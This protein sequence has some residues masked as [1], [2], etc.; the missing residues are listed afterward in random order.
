MKV[1]IKKIRSTIKDMDKT[2]LFVSIA[3]IGFGLLN[4]VT[5]SSR[6]AVSQDVQLYHYFY[7]HSFMVILGLILA[8]IILKIPTVF[9]K[10]V[11]I[12]PVLLLAGYMIL[13]LISASD[14][15][16]A[17]NWSTFGG[18]TFQPSEIAKVLGIAI[19]AGL[20]DKHSRKLSS[21]KNKYTEIIVKIIVITLII[22]IIVFFQK[23]FGTM[24]IQLT[25]F[26][27]MFL[28][29]PIRWRQKFETLG[30]LFIVLVLG[31]S[32]M[33]SVKG[34]FF[35]DAQQSRLTDY[36]HPCNNYEDGG[37]QVCNGIIAIN[38]GGLFGLGIG[39]SKQK[40]SYIPEP[41]TD[42]VFS[43]IAEEYG[44]I[45]VTPIFIAYII[46][47]YRIMLLGSRANSIRGRYICLGVGIYIFVHIFIN[48]GG[49]FA[50]IPLTG[51]P[52]P[53]LSYGGSYTIS[54]IAALALVQR[55]HIETKNQRIK[56]K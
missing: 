11:G 34:Y 7:R 35:T 8:Y 6:E 2:L 10:N 17:K 45:R 21:K 16:G 41:H 54:L 31:I 25:I 55:V 49:L 52:L 53:F 22:P 42:S 36:L 43:I 40:Y 32:V 15:R 37:Y 1:V 29:S 39:K 20:Y 12:F 3:M 28:F 48:L 26:I 46:I 24:V 9:Y 47:L 38:D 33:V 4:I 50:L 27:G 56:I 14:I 44:L 30:V 19:L 5:A 13:S 23:D 18:Q 51:V